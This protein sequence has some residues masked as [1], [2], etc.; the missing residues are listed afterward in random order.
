MAARRSGATHRSTTGACDLLDPAHRTVAGW[1][2]T[3]RTGPGGH[4]F[5]SL[6]V[7]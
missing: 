7:A 6:S 4:H 2:S 1:A 3:P 5:L